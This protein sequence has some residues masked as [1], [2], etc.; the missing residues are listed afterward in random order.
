MRNITEN[1]EGMFE[2]DTGRFR[3]P[4]SG[5][6]EP[7]GPPPDFDDGVDRFRA[8]DGQ[9]KDRSAD[10]F[11]EKEEVRTGSLDPMG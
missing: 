6:F 11:D 8:A 2:L 5:E 3:D 7:G 4:Q 10:L 9:F 1:R